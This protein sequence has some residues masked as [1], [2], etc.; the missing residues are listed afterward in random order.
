MTHCPSATLRPAINGF[1]ARSLLF[2]RELTAHA[3]TLPFITMSGNSRT[4][5]RWTKD[6]VFILPSTLN[7]NI[8]EIREYILPNRNI[9][10]S[11][12]AF[13]LASLMP[14]LLYRFVF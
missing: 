8:Q 6:Q 1:I 11:Y 10:R 5:S 7:D 14:F 9:L 4:G 2:E 13:L 12:L 3:D